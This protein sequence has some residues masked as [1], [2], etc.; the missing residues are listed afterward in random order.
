M[1]T[2]LTAVILLLALW[3]IALLGAH[4][5]HAKDQNYV[6]PLGDYHRLNDNVETADAPL[7][8]SATGYGQ[9]EGGCDFIHIKR[10]AL[11]TFAITVEC[12]WADG[13]PFIKH[14]RWQILRTNGDVFLTMNTKFGV[15]HW[16]RKK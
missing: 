7:S 15:S 11:N 5:A 6:F 8:I 16:K 1:K 3:G 12:A 13:K 14:E 10:I 4:A 2:I 9:D